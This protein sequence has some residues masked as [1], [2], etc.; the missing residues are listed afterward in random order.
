M[1]TE[2]Q[3]I[4]RAQI[5]GKGDQVQVGR[6]LEEHHRAGGLHVVEADPQVGRAAVLGGMR[7]H[8][9]LPAHCAV[10]PSHCI[11]QTRVIHASGGVVI[12]VHRDAVQ[13]VDRG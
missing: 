12:A 10:L 4:D 8:E 13:P 5:P 1:S 7:R 9:V 6:A 2:V 11:Q 3:Q